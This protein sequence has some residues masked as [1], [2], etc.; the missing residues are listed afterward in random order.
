LLSGLGLMG[1]AL[2]LIIASTEI[3]SFVSLLLI[4]LVVLLVSL[5]IVYTNKFYMFRQEAKTINFKDEKT[6]SINTVKLYKRL[7][8]GYINVNWM[9][10]TSY[11]VC[12]LVIL[13]NF[14]VSWA[15]TKSL[16]Y[17]FGYWDFSG[18]LFW[19]Y[20][21]FE[22]IFWCTVGTLLIT[23]ILHAVL[24][25]TNYL[26]YSRIENFYNFLIVPQEEIDALKK[27]K[28]R[29]DLIIFICSLLIVGL[30]GFLIYKLVR[31]NK[32]TQVVVK[33]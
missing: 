20:G 15:M 29:R 26:R 12:L 14:I 4:P 32:T 16:G 30:I 2:Y 23:V 27:Q 18:E 13:I 6:L 19:K 7:K 31:R 1:W 11:G 22:I 24:L 28:N 17:G 3:N 10:A 33:S 5:W 8:V 21:I 9:S 25:L